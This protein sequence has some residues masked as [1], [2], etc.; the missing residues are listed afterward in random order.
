MRFI[1]YSILAMI[2]FTC[3]GWESCSETTY[4]I[5]YEEGASDK[6]EI[7]EILF[8]LAKSIESDKPISI[9]K[10]QE[11][12]SPF[13]EVSTDELTQTLAKKELIPND[14]LDISFTYFNFFKRYTDISFDLIMNNISIKDNEAEAIVSYTFKALPEG[15]ETE[16]LDIVR[17]DIFLFKRPAGNWKIWKWTAGFYIGTETTKLKIINRTSNFISTL[18]YPN[19]FY[20]TTIHIDKKIKFLYLAGYVKIKIF[21]IA[22]EVVYK[23]EEDA[24]TQEIEWN[25]KNLDGELVSS[26]IYIYSIINEKGKTFTGK[27]GV[28]R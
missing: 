19:P 24:N 28:I 20:P 10:I 1:R 13:Y 15:T 11:C 21:N 4:I 17:K 18:A 25:G 9:Y 16:N 8:I 5:P 6:K 26:G 14:Y 27:I 3:V 7:Q 22:G 12:F 23:F 2:L